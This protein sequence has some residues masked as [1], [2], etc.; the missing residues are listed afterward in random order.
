MKK[1]LAIAPYRFLPARS[2]GHRYI[3]GWYHALSQQVQLTVISTADNTV[4]DN[5]P[6]RVL[7]LLP[8][9]FFRYG[10][11]T[12]RATI[13]DLIQRNQYELLVWEHP[14]YAWLAHLIKKDTGIPYLLRAHNIEYQR[15]RTL[16]KIWW[17]LLAYYEKW[18][19]QVADSISF[20]SN[21]DKNFAI[22]NWKVA[23]QRCIDIPFGIQNDK[24]PENKIQIR[25]QIKE[26][27]SINENEK[28]LLFNGPL[29]Y[30]PNREALE[31]IIQFI[32][33]SLLTQ[34]GAFKI[35]L[36]G[37]H[38]P[39]NWKYRKT[40][41]NGP[42]IEA[43]FVEDINQYVMA[44][45]LLLNPIQ[46]GGGVKTKIIESISMGTP[47]LTTTAGAVGIDRN[48]TGNY[49]QVLS[50]GAWDQWAPSIATLLHNTSFEPASLTN[51]FMHYNW[52]HI[53]ERVLPALPD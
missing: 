38:A 29:D 4:V 47:V 13:R 7:P 6:Y 16:H 5:C 22:T 52:T 53:I 46:K 45:D 11:L 23:P 35:L 48:I 37:G 34:V 30:K 8:D 24:I 2:G 1:V 39:K 20:I 42:Y 17:P 40:I 26:R 51:F 3:E 9:S 15:F 10:D 12:L 32:V 14:Y 21:N 27:Y 31:S 43:G 33:P 19:F 25:Q 28:I 49:M 41:Q 18:S 44:A 50:D 36:C